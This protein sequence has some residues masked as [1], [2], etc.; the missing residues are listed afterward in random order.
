MY[1]CTSEYYLGSFGPRLVHIIKKCYK[2][3]LR[4]NHYNTQTVN[5]IDFVFS[6]LYKTPVLYVNLYLGSLHKLRA[7]VMRPDYPWG[8]KLPHLQVGASNSFNF[9]VYVDGPVAIDLFGSLFLCHPLRRY[10][11]AVN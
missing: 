2:H 3:A 6:T 10:S 11:C 4:L 8:S 9:S 5:T 1:Q 7:D